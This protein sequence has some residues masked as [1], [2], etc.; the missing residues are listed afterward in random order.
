MRNKI[1]CKG[2]Y[3]PLVCKPHK[4]KI[5][6]LLRPDRA[7]D[8]SNLDAPVG[9]IVLDSLKD[10]PFFQEAFEVALHAASEGK[11]LVILAMTEAMLEFTG[12]LRTQWDNRSNQFPELVFLF[13]AV[14]AWKFACKLGYNAEPITKEEHDT[15]NVRHFAEI[16]K[17]IQGK[18]STQD[19]TP[20][21]IYVTLGAHG[22]LGVD[23]T[24]GNVCYASHYPTEGVRIY[25]T[26]GCGDA[27][28][29]AISLLEWAVRNGYPDIGTSL[30]AGEPATRK[31]DEMVYFMS[32]ATATAYCKAT[33]RRGRV[34]A[35]AVRDLLT[36]VYLGSDLLPTPAGILKKE[37]SPCILTDGRLVDPP[38]ARH[39][40]ITDDLD[41]LMARQ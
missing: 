40:G 13:N 20:P 1:I 7:R 31:A 5:Q 4:K 23:A 8:N 10:R 37:P 6:R 30:G 38:K 3:K 29:A 41:R 18:F 27:Y 2:H 22:S 16:A 25:D 11:P 36:N 34:L 21:R 28:C 9:T 39:Q 32:V 15:P 33:N 12:W 26:N 35:S 17:A 19:I 24:S 14:E